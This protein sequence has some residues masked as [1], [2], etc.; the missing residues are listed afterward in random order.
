MVPMIV[1]HVDPSLVDGID[2]DG[3]RKY[4]GGWYVNSALNGNFED[5]IITELI[6]YV[7]ANYRTK[8]TKEFR[9]IM[10]QSMGGFGS[11]HLGIL[12]PDVFIGFG[13]ASGTPFWIFLDTL[14]LANPDSLFFFDQHILSEIPTT[15]PNTGKITPDNGIFSNDLFSYAAAFSSN[16]V[17]PPY[18]VDLPFIINPDGTPLLTA[19]KLTPN[20]IVIPLWKAEDP[21]FLMDVHSATMK[22]QAI[23]LDGGNTEL[24]NNV[25]AR[26]FSDKLIANT[27]DHEFILYGGGHVTCLTTQS[28]S[29]HA[30]MFKF[31]SG[32]FAESGNFSDDIRSKIIGIGTIILENGATM[33]IDEGTILGIETSPDLGIDTTNIEIIIKDQSQLLIGNDTTPG[34]ALQIGNRFGKASLINNNTDG[35]PTTLVDHE[36][37][38]KITLNGNEARLEI[39]KKG[40]LGLGAG[41]VGQDSDIP[42]F[43]A[44]SSLTNVKNLTIAIQSG[45][46]IHN[47]IFSSN[48]N[49]ASLLA[50]GPSEN[51]TFSLNPIKGLMLGGGN[52]AC[53]QDTIFLHPTILNTSGNIPPGGIRVNMQTDP[54][55]MDSFYMQPIGSRM[56]NTNTLT[57]GVLSSSELLDDREDVDTTPFDITTNSLQE[58][59]TFLATNEYL[60]ESS[61]E[62]NITTFDNTI[63]I[64]C[65][66]T[67]KIVRIAEPDIPIGSNQKINFNKILSTG[68]IGVQIETVNGKRVPIRVY[69]LK[70]TT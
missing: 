3:F 46:F 55:E 7:D 14:N 31:F 66:D 10:G 6:P 44:I 68:A 21:F 62:G 43:W 25:G 51:F 12:Y 52:L 41:V 54:N 34:G 40:F 59:C 20:P 33:S 37:S 16:L 50:L 65:I 67:G 24:A 5:Y 17:N 29:R 69:D 57:A 45:T 35:T 56:F 28:C 11:L 22:K 1:V 27:V 64:A 30:T 4:R 18:F 47:Q 26:I 9:T 53:I 23:Y 8:S 61:K 70:P 13:S 38:G 2:V 58:F 63:L 19:G 60:P 48:K 36:V 32:K 39:G 15:G 42:N 49:S